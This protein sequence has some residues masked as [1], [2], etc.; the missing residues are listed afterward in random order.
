MAM[1]ATQQRSAPRRIVVG[2]DGSGASLEALR[3]AVA[4]ARAHGGGDIR[5]VLVWTLPYTG[6]A[7]SMTPE[8]YG[9]PDPTM[10]EQESRSRLDSAIGSLGDTS[11]VQVHAEV[12][13]GQ[14]A[15]V[16]KELSRDAD[17]IV[18]GSRGHGGFSAL[19]LGSVSAQVVRH[20]HCSV[21]VIRPRD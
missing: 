18:V 7:T 21:V 20:A 12:I 1:D 4:E 16:L 17:L 10:I 2:V 13:E 19:L 9:L 6:L 15:G 8:P 11:P 14:P 5:A 3:W